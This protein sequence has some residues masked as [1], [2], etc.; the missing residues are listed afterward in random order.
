M[1]ASK[2]LTDEDIAFNQNAIKQS[3]VQAQGRSVLQFFIGDDYAE[4]EAAPEE[5]ANEEVTL[6]EYGDDL[7]VQ[8]YR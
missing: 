3:E 5:V 8:H 1:P 7:Y 4:D 2:L 6:D